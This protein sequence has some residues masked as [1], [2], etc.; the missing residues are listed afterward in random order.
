[1]KNT[2]KS[3]KTQTPNISQLLLTEEN[4]LGLT[5]LY[6]TLHT[7]TGIMSEQLDYGTEEATSYS[8]QPK[9]SAAASG[10]S[11]RKATAAA[12]RTLT[13]PSAPTPLH[14]PLGV[15][16][17]DGTMGLPPKAFSEPPYGTRYRAYTGHRSSRPFNTRNLRDDVKSTRTFFARMLDKKKRTWM[18]YHLYFGDSN[19]WRLFWFF[20][21]VHLTKSGDQMEDLQN[22]R[23]Q[24]PASTLTAT[25]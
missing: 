6:I 19:E 4:W 9:T 17:P 12:P 22:C 23:D 3:L 25:L 11:Q 20:A 5:C 21:P 10:P 2:T 7:F 13:A 14:P 8:T 15:H 18:S 16:Q 24:T 1:M